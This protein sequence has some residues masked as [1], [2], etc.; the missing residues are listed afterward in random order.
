MS[1]RVREREESYMYVELLGSY[2]L[3]MFNSLQTVAHL[4]NTSAPS[5]VSLMTRF[6]SCSETIQY[7]TVHVVAKHIVF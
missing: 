3:A 6:Q 4:S 5:S 1:E 2:F 7:V